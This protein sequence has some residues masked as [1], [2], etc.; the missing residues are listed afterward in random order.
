MFRKRLIGCL[1]PLS[2]LAALSACG[3]GHVLA[4]HDAVVK[5]SPIE[6]NPSALYFSIQGGPEATTLEDVLSASVV[7]VAM[8][9]TVRDPRTGVTAMKPLLRVS[10]PA[11]EDTDFAPGSRHVMLYGINLPARRLNEVNLIFVFG[12]GERIAVTAPIEAMGGVPITDG[13]KDMDMGGK[14]GQPAP[15]SVP[16]RAQPGGATAAPAA[17]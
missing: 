8:H 7:R 16:A 2:A 15:A 14:A 9:E 17:I 5:L 3:Q 11:K 6:D 13:F 1:L 4:V 12:S 10:V